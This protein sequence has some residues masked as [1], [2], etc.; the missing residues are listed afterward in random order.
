[1]GPSK[2]SILSA[3]LLSRA[4][5]VVFTVCF[6]SFADNYDT[7]S[8]LD[9]DCL[10]T[11]S[12]LRQ[13]LWLKSGT[14]PVTGPLDRYITWDAV[15]F[16]R[17]AKC[18][19][20]FEQS[21]AF[22]PAL[23]LVMRTLST[24][25]LWP[26]SGLLGER[27]TLWL[28]GLLLSNCAFVASAVFL[29]RLGLATLRDE[30]LAYRAALLYCWNP[31]SIFYSSVYTES[32][33]ALA[34][35]A[36]MLYLV[37]RRRALSL[38]LLAASTSVRSNGILH[39]YF[40]VFEAAA[41]ASEH[42]KEALEALSRKKEPEAPAYT[43]TSSALVYALFAVLRGVVWSA[44]VCTPFALFQAYGYQQVCVKGDQRQPWCSNTIPYI[45]GYVQDRYWNVGFLRYFRLQQLP[46]FLL[47]SPMIALSVAAVVSYAL[48]DPARF[49]LLHLWPTYT[50]E[51]PGK[52]I[53]SSED[54]AGAPGD[55]G[56]KRDRST[57]KMS[58]SQLLTKRNGGG[59]ESSQPF[60][61]ALSALGDWQRPVGPE[62]GFFSPDV[63][64]F[65]HQLAIMVC[66]AT[67]IMHVQVATRFLSAS[68]VVYWYAAGL[69]RD[70]KQA[71]NHSKEI[72]RGRK[73][74]PKEFGSI[75]RWIW[76]TF[77]GYSVIGTLLFTNFYPFT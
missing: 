12:N 18:G 24:T 35:F 27:G 6:H 75:Y 49:F 47:A 13:K 34:S 65:T 68:P 48:H 76:G 31:A 15:H 50:R 36:G 60:A 72:S 17:I 4:T 29:H 52:A 20:E 1:M 40:F 53:A 66:V 9:A 11:H 33:F 38:L 69:C 2:P 55:P 5:I 63:L 37:Q 73:G 30:E 64:C 14:S 22:F 61:E 7:S 21:F 70:R 43:R 74:L 58:G 42:W 62:A 16:V 54:K 45:Y 8:E 19:Y 41:T 39:A 26:L 10:H 46:N 67:L 25:F 3:A 44:L 32:L 59:V 56:T 28:S 57:S 23:P 77:I 71:R 51:P